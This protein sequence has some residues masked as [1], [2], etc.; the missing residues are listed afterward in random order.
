MKTKSIFNYFH[1]RSYRNPIAWSITAALSGLPF[2]Q[3]A[4]AFAI[5]T[6]NPDL[7][8]AWDNTLKYSAAWRV[9]GQSDEV[10]P[11]FNP[12]LDDGDNNFDRGLI[13]NRFDILS[14]LDISYRRSY[15]AMS[16][17]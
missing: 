8:V 4:Q 13:S 3:D 15:G 10:R 1:A 17:T 7:A 2:V 12:N 11:A 5:D 16:S 14:E 9:E 6:G